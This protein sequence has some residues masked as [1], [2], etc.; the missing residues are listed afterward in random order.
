MGALSG[1]WRGRC[2][3]L[4]PHEKVICRNKSTIYILLGQ[5]S[6]PSHSLDGLNADM[7][8][9]KLCDSG[10][11]AESAVNLPSSAEVHIAGEY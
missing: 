9:C 3:Q 7:H 1:V 5:I 4:C 10:Y 11:S 6:A 8:P 2:I